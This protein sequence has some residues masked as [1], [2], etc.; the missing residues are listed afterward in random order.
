MREIKF[1][2]WDA[3]EKRFIY[4][5]LGRW[6]LDITH[7]PDGH[8]HG[9]EEG[10]E[11]EAMAT[12]D[13]MQFTGL[14]DKNGKEIYEGDVVNVGPHWSD[15]QW[16]IKWNLYG[17]RLRC[18]RDFKT[19]PNNDITYAPKDQWIDPPLHPDL[20]EIIGNIYENPALLK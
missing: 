18:V 10:L 7:H 11:L 16:E 4:S 20:W 12:S 3:T 17:F 8:M 19:G 6:F 2:A 1:R 15:A 13:W 5:T 9:D 14:H